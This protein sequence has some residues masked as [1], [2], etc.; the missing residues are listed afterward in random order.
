MRYSVIAIEREYA[1]GGREIGEKLAEKLGIPCYQ[2]EI[3]EKAA[4]KLNLPP[5]QLLNAEEKMTGS[6]LFGLIAFANATS[7]TET[8][9]LTIE[10][11]LAIAEADVIRDLAMS[12]CVIIGR[13]ASAILKDED[14]V[15]RVFIH[16]DYK[17]RIDRAVHIYG[18]DPNQAES[19][20]HRYDKRRSNYFKVTT[21]MGW[22]AA[23]IY[24]LFLDSDKLGID[25][26]TNILYM[27]CL[28]D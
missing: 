15:L 12:P 6:L 14:N 8:D 7:G 20:L 9:F 11:K 3:L 5:E 19:V 22:K 21:N 25:M 2:Q 10:Q 1:S 18:I 26:V 4:A 16:A 23:E 27:V 24:H 17:A 28:A 13:G